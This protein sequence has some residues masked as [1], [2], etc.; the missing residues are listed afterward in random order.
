MSVGKDLCDEIVQTAREELGLK[1]NAEG[2]GTPHDFVNRLRKRDFLRGNEPSEKEWQLKS[3]WRLQC[4]PSHRLIRVL[5]KNPVASQPTQSSKSDLVKISVTIRNPA[6]P[7]LL[8][9]L[10]K[11]RPNSE[12]ARAFSKWDKSEPGWRMY[13]ESD[14]TAEAQRTP[15]GAEQNNPSPSAFLSKTSA[16]LR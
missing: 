16:P 10:G 8:I 9:T 13:A 15:R 3:A 14:F 7:E 11:N 6:L 2:S 4:L 1:R 5:S 12:Q